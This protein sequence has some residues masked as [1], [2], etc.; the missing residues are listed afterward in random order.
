MEEGPAAKGVRDHQGWSG[1]VEEVP[2]AER[3]RET[4]KERE[5][6]SG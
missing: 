3:V 4:E 6:E 5:R 1:E 2:V